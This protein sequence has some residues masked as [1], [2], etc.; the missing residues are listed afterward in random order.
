MSQTT[1]TVDLERLIQCWEL[2]ETD[3]GMN[4]V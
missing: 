4:F 3:L 2:S 1:V